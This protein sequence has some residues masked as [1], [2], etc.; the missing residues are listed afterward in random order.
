[1]ICKP[2]GRPLRLKPQGIEIAGKPS[3]FMTRVKRVAAVR[4]SSVTPRISTLFC[5]ILGA[6]IGVVGVKMQ[7]TS[8]NSLAN[9]RPMRRRV[10]CASM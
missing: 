8:S 1:M 6:V 2:M 5:P 10:R 7:S 9:W 3:A 4:T